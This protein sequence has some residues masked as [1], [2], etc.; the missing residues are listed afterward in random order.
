MN[1]AIIIVNFNDED[2]TISYVE[3]INK[4]KVLNRIIVVDNKSTTIGAFNKL[5]ELEKIDKKITVIET[6]KN[7]GYSYGN[8]FGVRYL[9][10][11]EKEKNIKYDYIIIS[12]PDIEIEEKAIVNS[13]SVLENNEDIASVAPRMFYKN[14]EPARRSSWKLRTPIRDMVHS[15]RFLELL[16]YKVLRNGEY[17][18]DEYKN[19]LL[20]VEAISGSFFIIKKDVFEKVGLFDENVFLFYE[21]DILGKKLQDLKFKIVSLNSEKFVHVESQTIGKVYNYFSKMNLLF[22]SKMYYQKEYNKIGIVENIIFNV[23]RICRFIEL[24]IEVPIRKLLKK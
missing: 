7:G 19:E 22:K 16:F 21:E 10:K 24:L 5:Q 3:K 11:E 2:E 6:E 17:K 12:N 15:T 18:E 23:L 8:N 14:G 4:Y 1:T 13:L 20:I 9:E